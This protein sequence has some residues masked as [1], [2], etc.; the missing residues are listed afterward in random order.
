MTAA[1]AVMALRVMIVK[2][3]G[4]PSGNRHAAAGCSGSSSSI[5][6]ASSKQVTQAT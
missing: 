1:A 3:I 2:R 4:G 6:T 5:A